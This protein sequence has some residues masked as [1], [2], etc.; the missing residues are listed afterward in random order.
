MAKISEIHR[1]TDMSTFIDVAQVREILSKIDEE[2]IESNTVSIL[3]REANNNNGG[4]TEYALNIGGYPIL[5]EKANSI[6][7]RFDNAID[8]IRET[9]QEIENQ[10]KKHRS[11][12]LRTLLNK[13]EEAITELKNQLSV[14]QS[15]TF[16][17]LTN[18]INSQI[19]HYE[20]KKKQILADPYY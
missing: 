2:A 19:E 13:V 20:E 7:N 11:E 5:F 1:D 3:Q 10:A 12:E 9:K 16:V 4:L 14:Y 15:E 17:P 18:M 8:Y 6:I